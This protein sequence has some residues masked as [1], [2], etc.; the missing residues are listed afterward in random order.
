MKWYSKSYSRNKKPFELPN[1]TTEAT[2]LQ[3]KSKQQK[4]HTGMAYKAMPAFAFT[5]DDYLTLA[6]TA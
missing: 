5:E 6:P 1:N 3:V 4:M 2:R